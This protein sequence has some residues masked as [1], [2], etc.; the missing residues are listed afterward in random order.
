MYVLVVSLDV[1]VVVFWH[2]DGGYL[3]VFRGFLL[4]YK[5]GLRYSGCLVPDQLVW[6]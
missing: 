1:V 6:L 2:A 3:Q 4:M 5:L